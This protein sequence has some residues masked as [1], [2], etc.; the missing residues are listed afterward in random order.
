[1][2]AAPKKAREMQALTREEIQRFLIHAKAEGYFELFLLEL[3]TGL[4]GENC[5][6]CNGMT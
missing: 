1:M 2:Q 6:P 4:R 5:W 3:T